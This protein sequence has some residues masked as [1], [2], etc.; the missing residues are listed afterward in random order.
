MRHG[1]LERAHRDDG[2]FARPQRLEDVDLRLCERLDWW[3][4]KQ[5][6]DMN[7]CRV[8][9]HQSTPPPAAKRGSSHPSFPSRNF[10]SIPDSACIDSPQ[11]HKQFSIAESSCS[12]RS[13]SFGSST[14][15]AKAFE[16]LAMGS[17]AVAAPRAPAEVDALGRTLWRFAIAR[18]TMGGAGIAAEGRTGALVE[19]GSEVV[20]GSCAAAAGAV[21]AAGFLT[22]TERGRNAIL[23]V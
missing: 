14:T 7:V 17:S 2:G 12:N 21:V 15:S 20:E 4:R 19:G 10:C 11:S 1:E 3:Y 18:G 13:A 8:Q 5:L 16:V 23:D 9:R 6:L 22:L